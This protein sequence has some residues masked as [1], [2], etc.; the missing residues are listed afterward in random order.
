MPE[1]R[2]TGPLVPLHL[3]LILGIGALLNA[4]NVDQ[5]TAIYENYAKSI[6]VLLLRS[7]DGQIKSQGSGF[8]VSDGRIV[9]NEHVVRGG[10]LLIDLGTARIPAIVERVD[11]INDLAIVRPSAELSA[12]VITLASALPTPGT[13]IYAL[14]NPVGLERSISTGIVS[15]IRNLNGRQLIQI[16]SP[17]SPGSSGGPI[18]N[19]NGETVGVAVGT[20]DQGQNLNFAVPAALVAKLIRGESPSKLTFSEKIENINDLIEKRN[21]YPF[22][23][24]A[25]S[26]YQKLDR[27]IDKVLQ[28]SLDQAG[29]S[30]DQLLVIA[31]KAESQNT[32]IAIAAAERALKV[33]E[34]PEA[35]AVL[36]K[37]MQ[38]KALFADESEASVLRER[39][40]IAFRLALSLSKPPGFRVYFGLADVLE[41]RGK[42]AESDTFFR[43]ALDASKATGDASG[44]AQSIRGLARVAYSLGQ[45]GQGNNWFQMLVNMNEATANDWRNHASRLARVNSHREAGI[46]FQ[47][48]AQLDGIWQDWCDAATQFLLSAD[49]S[50]D[51][52][53]FSARNCIEKGVGQKQ[54][55]LRLSIAH[56]QIADVLNDRG[57]Y[58]EALSHAKE[59]SVLD[60]SSSFAYDSMAK[61]L[62]GLR[63][64]QEAINA[65]NSAIRL[66]DGRYGWMHFHL[67]SAYFDI[68]NWQ[69]SRQ[70]FEKA[71]ELERT[72]DAAAYNVAI[73]YERLGYRNDAANWYEEVLRR[74]PNHKERQDILRRIQNLRR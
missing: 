68:E 28:E 71:A 63:R 48:A 74:A 5:A 59:S 41:D 3:V 20:L 2:P 10:S 13:A 27:E 55:E 34:T 65:S 56:R 64:F 11:L 62:L 66:S 12:R 53:L 25:D 31:N 61:S 67:G 46:A 4:Q 38:F 14:G 35:A 17:I 54:S 51:I 37:A 6:F 23:A 45:P 40:E 70:S 21:H 36:G 42:Y 18:I 39:A 44:Q 57:V 52:V 22:S 47:Q 1:V 26:D 43:R 15:A 58:Q 73:C 50:A 32:D 49:D 30:S 7:D 19:S 33:R 69:L 72:D 24:D 60:P 8:L 9:T 16:T 29:S